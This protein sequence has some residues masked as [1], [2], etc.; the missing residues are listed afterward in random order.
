MTRAGISPVNESNGLTRSDGKR[1]DG[2]TTIPWH[3]GRSVTW[4]HT[5]T[6]TVAASYMAMS[7]VRAASTAEATANGNDDK[8]IEISRVHLFYP[9]AF[10]ITGRINQVSELGRRISSSTDNPRETSFQR[11]SVAVQR[12]NAVSISYSFGLTQ[13]EVAHLPKHIEAH[14]SLIFY[15]V[16]LM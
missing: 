2:L 16:F 10:E 3:D 4:D 12:F 15:T 14:H 13:C 7:S 6:N 8:C 1:P 11:L 9:I 5:V